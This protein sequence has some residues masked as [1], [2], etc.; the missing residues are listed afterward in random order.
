MFAEAAMRLRPPALLVAALVV[1]LLLPACSFM[2]NHSGTV[3]GYVGGRTLL[4]QLQMWTPETVAGGL[5]AYAIHDPLAPTW[6]IEASASGEDQVRF[7]L[8]MKRWVSGGEGEARQVFL[9][10]ARQLVEEGGYAGYD[11]LSYEE[12]IEATRPFARRVASGE[13]RLVRS[14]QFPTL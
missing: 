4:H 11:I 1:P 5:V 2:H 7:Q 3:A 14:R 6:A 13:I 9:R 8:W 10:N 12:G